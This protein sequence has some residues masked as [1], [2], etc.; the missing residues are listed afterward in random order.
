MPPAMTKISRR[1]VLG[2]L[3]GG[4]LGLG[5]D[6]PARAADWPERSLTWIVPFAKKGSA[7]VYAALMAAQVNQ[8]LRQPVTIDNL[9]GAGGTLAATLFTRAAP[10]GYTWFVGYT[11]LVYASV[12]YPKSGAGFD[13]VRDFEPV[14][15]FAREPLA[16]VINTANLPGIS[17]LSALIDAV[18]R[19][20]QSIEMGC[21]E[22]GTVSHLAI[23]LLEDRASLELRHAPYRATQD[24]VFALEH[25]RL[26]VAFLPLAAVPAHDNGKLKLLAVAARRRDPEF[27]E[28][29][30][31]EEAGIP[32]FRISQWFGLFARKGTPPAILDAMHDAVQAG[33]SEEPVK[34]LWAKQA[35]RVEPESRSDFARFVTQE[36]GRWSRLAKAANLQLE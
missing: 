13:I 15:A 6:G 7:E 31:F 18:K 29:P 27:P 33:L 34:V 21:D 28:V 1:T 4:I 8:R 23:N 10:D 25:G 11:G 36:T 3:P 20:P 19:R 24:V 17:S 2:G 12:L 30:T 35:A 14:S 22:R 9:S 5:V 32:D 16:L 26:G